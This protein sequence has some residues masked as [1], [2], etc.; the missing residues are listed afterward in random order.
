MSD[1]KWLKNKDQWILS[2]EFN[3]ASRKTPYPKVGDHINSWLIIGAW[4]DKRDTLKAY[5]VLCEGCNYTTVEY[6]KIDNLKF[7]G[8]K[9]CRWC[10]AN[11]SSKMQ[12][13]D[14]TI[15]FRETYGLERGRKL[16]QLYGKRFERPHSDGQPAP[17]FYEPWKTDYRAF[18]EYIVALP[19]FDKWPEYS[20]DR[21]NAYGPYEPGN[22]RFATFNEQQRNK[23]DTIYIEFDGVEIPLTRFTELALGP[24]YKGSEAANLIRNSYNR[25]CSTNQI[26]EELA[27]KVR[28]NEWTKDD[29][30]RK[31]FVRWYNARKSQ[32]SGPK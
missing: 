28:A 7:S 24:E 30:T 13:Y 18:A 12:A 14:C 6:M 15:Y 9:Q 20:L 31:H 10:A 5:R 25:G 23:K 21:I 16:A 27:N 32:Y 29:P 11:A 19:N 8:S 2:Y 17:R 22:L 3:D 1:P 26:I 4:V